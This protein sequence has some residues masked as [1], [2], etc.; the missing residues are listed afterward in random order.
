MAGCRL[1]R[2]ARVRGPPGAW[3]AVPL[4]AVAK[5]RPCHRGGEGTWPGRVAHLRGGAAEPECDAPAAVAAPW[6]D[7]ATENAPAAVRRDT[8]EPAARPG[9]RPGAGRRA[10]VGDRNRTTGRGS[11]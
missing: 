2:G 4:P 7:P 5:I 3:A 6:M 1:G 11:R 8:G 10:I 9:T